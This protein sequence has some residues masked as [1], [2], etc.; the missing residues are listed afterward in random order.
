MFTLMCGENLAQ[1]LH[2]NTKMH[3]P[4]LNSSFFNDKEMVHKFNQ[5]VLTASSWMG[6]EWEVLSAQLDV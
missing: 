5:N 4:G 3:Y 6:L 1:I 2:K